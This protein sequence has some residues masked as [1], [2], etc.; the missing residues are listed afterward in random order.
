MTCRECERTVHPDEDPHVI[1]RL[2]SGSEVVLCSGCLM[3]FFVTR[4]HPSDR[5]LF[6]ALYLYFFLDLHDR[7]VL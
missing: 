2:G 4:G 1:L 5:D 3:A 6:Y 7:R